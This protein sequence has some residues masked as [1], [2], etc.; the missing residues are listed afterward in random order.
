M[1]FWQLAN[2]TV[3]HAEMTSTVGRPVI[4]TLQIGRIA[5]EPGDVVTRHT[6]ALQ[7]SAS[8]HVT[9]LSFLLFI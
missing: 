4:I 8:G 7:P 2:R 6:A 1:N 9:S 5:L 3:N